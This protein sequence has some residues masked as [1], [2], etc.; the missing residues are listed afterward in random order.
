MQKSIFL[1][2]LYNALC[3]VSVAFNHFIYV[4]TPVTKRI[5]TFIYL[6]CVFQM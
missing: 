1:I 4:G 5:K 6:C 3:L 2:Y